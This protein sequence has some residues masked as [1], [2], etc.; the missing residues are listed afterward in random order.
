MYKL[1]YDP[2]PI[3]G[4]I[5]QKVSIPIYEEQTTIIG[6]DDELDDFGGWM[7][8]RW[9]KVPIYETI[10]V[11][12]GSKDIYQVFTQEEYSFFYKN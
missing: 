6:Y 12:V 5:I 10:Y 1:D 2:G 8:L 7:A 4:H 11:I 3:E 9:I